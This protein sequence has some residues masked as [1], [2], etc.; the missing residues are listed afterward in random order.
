MNASILIV[1]KNRADDL[2]HTLQAMKSVHVPDA[3][4]VELVV[5]DNG[6]TDDTSTVVASCDW[7]AANVRYI[8]DPRPG[9]CVGL[10]RGL[11]ES[12]GDIILFTDDDIRPPA[13][14]IAAMCDPIARGRSEAVSGGVRLAGHLLRPWMT[15]VHRTW[16]ASTEWLQRGSPQS[17]VGANMAFSRKV[18]EKVPA[19]DPELGPGASG[20]GDDA[21]FAS[22]LLAAGY[23]IHDAMDVSIEHHFDPSRLTRESWLTA[24]EKRGRSHAYR[25]HHWEHWGCRLGPLKIVRAQARLAAWRAR[26]KDKLQDEGC[27]PEE[28]DLVFD[29][30]LVRAHVEENKRPRNYERQGL[31]KKNQTF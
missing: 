27:D 30:A 1:T 17:M 3:L 24:A 5:I 28:L 8:L 13:G 11:V 23:G 21:L 7:R 19:F 16:L 20:F 2:A 6:S 14:W 9:K 29:L 4:G 15:P 31:V 12:T 25:G 22:Q 10:N 18:L 26:N